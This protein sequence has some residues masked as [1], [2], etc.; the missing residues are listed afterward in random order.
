GASASGS[1]NVAVTNVAPSNVQLSL[2]ASTIIENGSTS[3]SG[4]FSDPGSLD[5]H[6]V[7]INWGDNSSSTL[8]LA[9][10]ALTFSGVSHS[11]LEERD[12]STYPV[13][14]TVTDGDGASGAGSTS[15]TVNNSPPSNL[16]LALNSRSI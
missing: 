7:V 1:T 5:T 9:A 2:S 3:L 15:M 12:G 8:N 14:V 16:Q 4:T 11:Y 6:T 10:G 13:T